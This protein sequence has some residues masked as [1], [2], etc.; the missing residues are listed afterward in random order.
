MYQ[1]KKY[2]YVCKAGVYFKSHSQNYEVQNLE[3][4]FTEHIDFLKR[5]IQTL[6]ILILNVT[7]L[8]LHF[9]QTKITLAKIYLKVLS[10]FI[11]EGWRR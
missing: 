8:K 7:C 2:K 10:E 3:I 4:K 6:I 11:F 5:I 1:V 9:F